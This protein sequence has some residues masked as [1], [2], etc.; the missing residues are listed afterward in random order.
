MTGAAKFFFD[1]A[2]LIQVLLFATLLTSI[3]VAE[4]VFCVDK[5]SEKWRHSYTNFLFMFT[6]LPI[7]LVLTFF[8]VAISGWAGANHWGI[9]FL[10]PHTNHAVVFYLLSFLLLDFFEYIYHVFMHKTGFLWKFH[11]VHHTDQDIDVSTTVREHPGE[12]F[13]RVCFLMVWV[14][15][16]GASMGVLVLRQTVQ[17]VANIFAHSKIR[18]PNHIEKAVGIVFIT[19]NLHHVH[20]H[21]Q[22][23][24]TDS[25]YGD[26]LSIWDRIFG[27]FKELDT[28]DTVFGIDTHFD[29][30][31]CN[32]F[33][34]T[35]K[36][37]FVKITKQNHDTLG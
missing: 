5:F 32:S 11:L 8:V 9:S 18:L 7:Q 37:P 28:K 4:V 27:T 31:T 35:V 30:A 15:I 33:K 34:E 26:V 17:S 3:W 1:H 23:P 16:S 14:F 6:A 13:V 22:L 12:T 20:H 29:P 21:Y 2:T 36:I 24:Y 19:P 10:F 25:N